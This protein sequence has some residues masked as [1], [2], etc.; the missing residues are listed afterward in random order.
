MFKIGDKIVYPMYGAGI[1]EDIVDKDILGTTQQYYIMR[2][3]VGS[4]TVMIPS[5][6]AESIGVRPI[7]DAV[8]ATVILDSVKHIRAD[9]TQNWS[10]RYRENM[11][12][13]K[14][15]DLMEV[16][17]VIVGLMQREKERGLSSSERKMLMSAKQIFVSEMILAAPMGK[18]EI[19]CEL[20][21]ALF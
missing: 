6:N 9:M 11:L 1:I 2:M 10:R 12:K 18:D 19:E 3:P 14:T 17:D 7:I 8:K 13:I 16:A 15:G 5:A 4:M 20:T 21:K